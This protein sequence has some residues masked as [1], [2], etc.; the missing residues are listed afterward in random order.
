LIDRWLLSKL[1]NLIK[2][3][4]TSFDKYEYSR[5]KADTENF[6]WHTFC[7]NYLEIVKDRIYNPDNRG[8]EERLSAQYTLYNGLLSVLKMMAPIMPYITEELYHGYFKDFEKENSIHMTKWPFL[9]IINKDAEK[10]GD[11]F[12][13]ALE[14]VRQAKAEKNLSLKNP[15][16][17]LIVKGKINS[18]EFEDV[19]VDLISA[20]KAENIDYEKLD[21]DSKDDEEVVIEL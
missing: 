21:R 3:S 19:K 2:D 13:Y 18:K 11:L 4:T 15:V 14:K 8:K 5:V 12:V 20:T 16:K 6:F 1:S 17:K 7:D 9:D 10:V